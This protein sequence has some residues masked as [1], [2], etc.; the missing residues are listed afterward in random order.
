M[1]YECVAAKQINKKSILT[2]TDL[3][4]SWGGEGKSVYILDIIHFIDYWFNS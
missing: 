1:P 2:F 4:R 3:I